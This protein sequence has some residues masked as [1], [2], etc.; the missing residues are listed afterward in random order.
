MKKDYLVEEYK[1]AYENYLVTFGHTSDL[2]KYYASIVF[3]LTTGIAAL[4]IR[5][6]GVSE[7]KTIH[8]FIII[9][10]SSLIVLG[11]VAFFVLRNII[12]ARFKC[13]K[14]MNYLRKKILI[15][16]PKFD[17]KE[18]MEICSFKEPKVTNASTLA[19]GVYI[20]NLVLFVVVT[21]IWVLTW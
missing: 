16:I 12:R 4:V 9:L 8:S 13:I 20:I 2:T 3:L 10:L 15:K 1:I 17:Y 19:H 18:Y 5:K 11:V 21:L 6:E 14:R 7:L